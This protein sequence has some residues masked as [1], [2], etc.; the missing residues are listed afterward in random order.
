MAPL[1]QWAIQILLGSTRTKDFFSSTGTESQI[2][3]HTNPELAKPNSIFSVGV[4]AVSWGVNR[5]DVYDGRYRDGILGHKYFNGSGWFPSDFENLGGPLKGP[6]LAISWGPNRND[7]FAVGQDNQLWHKALD[8]STWSPSLSGWE[9]LGGNLSFSH[10]LAAVS[11]IANRL[12]VFGVRVEDDG[13]KSLWRKSWNGTSWAPSA[14]GFEQ[15]AGKFST[16]PSAA[17]RVPHGLSVY[18]VDFQG[19]LLHRWWD[20]KTNTWENWITIGTQFRSNPAAVSINSTRIDVLCIGVDGLLYDVAWV[21]GESWKEKQGI[22]E[23]LDIADFLSVQ[24]LGNG[25]ISIFV[26]DLRRS[27]RYSKLWSGEWSSWLGHGGHFMSPLVQTSWGSERLDVFG[28]DTYERLKH[29]SYQPGTGWK[30]EQYR[31]E[32]IGTWMVRRTAGKFRE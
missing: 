14:L 1:V 18:I 6:P 8:G 22:S 25:M 28:L 9:N 13:S 15:I 2:K 7:I 5:I 26:A 12:D 27:F 17:S 11:R 16:A 30:P 20:S 19:N 32:D 21:D 31:W 24:K 10:P 23:Y 3:H 4:T 29:Q